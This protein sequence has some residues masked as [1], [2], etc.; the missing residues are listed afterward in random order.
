MKKVF[1]NIIGLLFIN[2]IILCIMMLYIKMLFKYKCIRMPSGN[3]GNENEWYSNHLINL[4]LAWYIPAVF[5]NEVRSHW[6]VTG[7]IACVLSL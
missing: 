3:W 6:C 2:N 4:F 5:I 1:Y 7:L